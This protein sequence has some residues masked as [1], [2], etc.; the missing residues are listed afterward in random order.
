MTDQSNNESGSRRLRREMERR[1]LL[2]EQIPRPPVG[3]PPVD[4]SPF[5]LPPVERT[6]LSASPLSASPLERSW[7]DELAPQSSPTADRPAA[8]AGP[9]L[10]RRELRERAAGGGAPTSEPQPAVD[11]ARQPPGPDAPRPVPTF[12]E[13]PLSRRELRELAEGTASTGSGPR[14]EGASRFETPPGRRDAASNG[15]PE[16]DAPRGRN[17]ATRYD[18]PQYDAPQYDAPRYAAPRY[19][20]PQYDAPQY[21]APRYDA[22]RVEAPRSEPEYEAP[23]YDAP[24]A[25]RAPGAERGQ[26]DQA[27]Q[28]RRRA[29]EDRSRPEPA[30]NPVEPD[31]SPA[32]PAQRTP[33]NWSF[34]SVVEAPAEPSAP[35]LPEP[36]P[37]RVSEAPVVDAPVRVS[38]QARAAAIRAQAARLQAEREEAARE[39]YEQLQGQRS[40]AQSAERQNPTP[41]SGQSPRPTESQAPAASPPASMWGQRPEPNGAA[42][43]AMAPE[44][45]A[46]AYAD[47]P[48]VRR[49]VLPPSMSAGTSPA[50]VPVLGQWQ[51]QAPVQPPAAPAQ[52]YQAAPAQQHQAAPAQQYQAAP[53][54]PYQSAPPQQY[55]GFPPGGP[56]P[57]NGQPFATVTMSPSDRGVTQT[58][59]APVPPAA[60]GPGGPG[61]PMGGDSGPLPRW[62][63]VGAG[64]GWSPTPSNGP[65]GQAPAGPVSPPPAALNGA[66]PDHDRDDED[67]DAPH[68]HPYT[69]LHMIVLVLVA[70]VLGMLIFM[71]VIKDATENGAAGPAGQ[72]SAAAIADATEQVGD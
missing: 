54:Q 2:D 31:S 45:D 67:D 70:F 50:D 11:A 57:A 16:Y 63:S 46:S 23:Q 5:D 64:T 10:S 61:G 47:R 15:A 21:D 20:A 18:P 55:Q 17:D 38:P 62:G 26:P 43:P 40:S 36:E 24:L 35:G 13:R 9:V 30:P 37:S 1:R 19:D 39:R 53:A 68:R 71:L 12:P 4:R 59:T 22:P 29:R 52:Q 42:Q 27:V 7:R 14:Q 65:N 48:S 58:V 56:M 72:I 51:G 32:R 69:W 44:A 8:S 60:G 28:S 6:P 66:R 33:A 34:G 49:V 41:T 25:D 3:L